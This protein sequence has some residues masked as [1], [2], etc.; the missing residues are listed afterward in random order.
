MQIKNNLILS[1]DKNKRLICMILRHKWYHKYIKPSSGYG[2]GFPSEFYC[3]RCGRLDCGVFTYNG[4]DYKF[5]QD[6]NLNKKEK[7]LIKSEDP[8]IGE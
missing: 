4:I 6:L 7:S 8:F 1:V 3:L 2:Y 5:I